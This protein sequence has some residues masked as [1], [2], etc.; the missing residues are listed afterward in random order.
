LTADAHFGGGEYVVATTV[1]VVSQDSSMRDSIAELIVTA[2]LQAE[3]FPSLEAWL[4]AVNRMR[5][6]CLVL[7]ASEQDFAVAE[8]LRTLAAVCARRPVVVLIDRGNVPIAV[9]VIKVGAADVIEKPQRDEILLES[10][11]RAA[12]RNGAAHPH[13]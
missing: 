8:R 4:A 5:R 7:D 13:A 6:G 2:G 11:K 10:I 3:T 12:A 1:F 9:R